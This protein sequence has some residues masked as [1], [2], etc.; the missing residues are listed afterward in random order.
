MTNIFKSLWD[1]LTGVGSVI[2]DVW[3]WLFEPLILNI[4]WLK[5]PVLLPDGIIIN[6]G[7]VPIELFGVSIFVLLAL[8]LVKALVP[9]T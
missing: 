8:W 5:I 4:E 9:L 2:S 7:I 1:L 3:E 6:M